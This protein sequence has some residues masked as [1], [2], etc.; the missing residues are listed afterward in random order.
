MANAAIPLWQTK[1]T[2]A[3]RQDPR[4]TGVLGFL[5][6][7][8]LIAW[9]RMM[10]S[11]IHPALASGSSMMPTAAASQMIVPAPGF[12][13]SGSAASLREWLSG[14]IPPIK[15]NIF[16]VKSE[17]FPQD[18]AKNSAAITDSGFWSTLEKSLSLQAD[19]KA[20]RAVVIASLKAEAATLRPTS[21]VMGPSP[22]AMIN[23]VLVREGDSV[24]S[25]RVLRIEPHGIIVEHEGIRLAIPMGVNQETELGK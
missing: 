8:L 9:A 6:V 16:L 12:K 10:I 2:V 19:Q 3:L 17:Y 5:V 13:P 4:K 7:V 21:T 22:R 18:T 23:G 24:G 20:K 14:P 11:Q 1:I 15:R 25:F